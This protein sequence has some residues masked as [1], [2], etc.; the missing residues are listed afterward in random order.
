MTDWAGDNPYYLLIVGDESNVKIDLD[1]FQWMTKYRDFE[2]L[3]WLR[4]KS[5]W[6]LVHKEDDGI[7]LAVFVDGGDQPYYTARH[8]GM[9]GAEGSNEIIAYGIGKKKANGEEHRL[10]LMPEGY[11][12]GDNDCDPFG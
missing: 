8:I 3:D 11:V 2:G 1:E 7:R 10:W 9:A 5:R 12:V 6:Y 4:I